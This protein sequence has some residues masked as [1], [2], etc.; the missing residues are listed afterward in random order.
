MVSYSCFHNF[1]MTEIKRETCGQR[2]GRKSKNAVTRFKGF[3]H[4]TDVLAQ[5]NVK[6]VQRSKRKKRFGV[7]Y[8]NLFENGGSDA[9]LQRCVDVACAELQEMALEVQDLKDKAAAIEEKTKERILKNPAKKW[10]NQNRPEAFKTSSNQTFEDAKI[11][12]YPAETGVTPVQ[13][14]HHVEVD[15]GDD[16][17]PKPSAPSS[18]YDH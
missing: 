13:E 4:K 16:D 9:E 11:P 2:V 3:C 10:N 6:E 8:M 18:D 7:D 17:P 1:A 12:A 15:G 5:I 14:T